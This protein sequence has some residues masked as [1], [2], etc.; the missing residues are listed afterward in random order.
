M[1]FNGALWYQGEANAGDPA[2]YCCRFP[3]MVADW[4][5]KMDLPLPFF[6]VQLAPPNSALGTGY[7]LIRQAQMCALKLPQTGYAIALDLGDPTSHAGSIH[8]RRKQEVG[9]RLMLA[10]N[11]VV[12]GRG[13]TQ[14]TYGPV[15]SSASV[16]GGVVE[17]QYQ[18]G[19]ANGLHLA[20]CAA[21]ETVNSK[22]CCGESPFE[23][24]TDGVTWSRANFAIAGETVKIA[25]KPGE[26]V[27]HV[28]YAWESM[29]Q[30]S[31]YAGQGAPGTGPNGTEPTGV[32]GATG[33]AA[34]PFLANVTST[35]ERFV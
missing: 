19:T 4:R 30:C 21:C 17:I 5:K 15:F 31:L 29:P 3:A 34:A 22:L 10:V 6:F 27:K 13:A 20:P 33:V 26:D 35:S 1:R 7:A 2:S 12:Y 18:R 16:A 23:L 24:S 32:P 8:P 14:Q 28:R 11:D 25:V 9:R